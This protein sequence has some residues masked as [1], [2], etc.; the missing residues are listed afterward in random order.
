MVNDILL[1]V[2]LMSMLHS[3]EVRVPLLDHRIVELATSIDENHLNGTSKKFILKK[4]FNKKLHPSLLEQ[5][6]I[7][8]GYKNLKFSRNDQ[9]TTFKKSEKKDYKLDNMKHLVE[10]FV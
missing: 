8:F 5:K 10:T 9:F 3:L 4:L 1:K 7:G 6:K 2:D